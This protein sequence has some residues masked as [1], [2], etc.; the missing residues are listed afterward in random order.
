MFAGI[1]AL[2]VVAAGAAGAAAR[3]C[4]VAGA[5]AAS[6]RIPK[7]NEPFAEYSNWRHGLTLVSTGFRSV[8]AC[9]GNQDRRSL[10]VEKRGK[11]EQCF[12]DWTGQGHCIDRRL[13]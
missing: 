6:T 1:A 7:K 8:R 4:F 2:A 10:T 13:Y 12:S 3:D 9:P 5:G 11:E